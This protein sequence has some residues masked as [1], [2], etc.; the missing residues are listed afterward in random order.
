MR[1][2]TIRGVRGVRGARFAAIVKVDQLDLRSMRAYPSVGLELI[3]DIEVPIQG[4]DTE[5]TLTSFRLG[6]SLA[7]R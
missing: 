2:R 7:S 5:A 4:N 6:R 3:I 1:D